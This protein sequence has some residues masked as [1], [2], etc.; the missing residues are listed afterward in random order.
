[1]NESILYAL[2]GLGMSFA[3]FTGLVVTL[4][5]RPE[6]ENWSAARLRM[7]GLL[8]SDSLSVLF[9]SLL[10]VALSLTDRTPDTIWAVCSVL[11]GSWFLLG[12][13]FAVGGEIRDRQDAKATPHPITFPVR[14]AIYSVALLMGIVLWLSAWNVGFERGQFLFV[15]GLMTLLAFAA[16]EFLYFVILV[17]RNRI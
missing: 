6:T 1:M 4:P 11:L 10:P 8:I 2:A 3:G 16:V 7:L 13:L 12:N 17:L 5:A 14:L 9:L 15:V